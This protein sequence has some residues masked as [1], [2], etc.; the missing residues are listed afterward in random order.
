MKEAFFYDWK[1][2][3]QNIDI[4][5]RL[6]FEKKEQLVNFINNECETY[7]NETDRSPVKIWVENEKEILLERLMTQINHHFIDDH[8]EREKYQKKLKN[9]SLASNGKTMTR[10]VFSKKLPS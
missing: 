2:E 5:G 1:N 3:K 8:E 7:F 9:I 10:S 6:V 4:T